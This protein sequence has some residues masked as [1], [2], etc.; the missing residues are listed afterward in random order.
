MYSNLNGL[1]VFLD[2]ESKDSYVWIALRP[3]ELVKEILTR[4]EIEAAAYKEKLI[5]DGFHVPVLTHNMRNSSSVITGLDNLYVSGNQT[6]AVNFKGQVIKKEEKTNKDTVMLSVPKAP[7]PENTV[8]GSMP[9]IIP[10][11]SEKYQYINEVIVETI[12]KYFDNPL[13]PVVVLISD[14]KRMEKILKAVAE[15]KMFM[16]KRNVMAYSPRSD[17][18]SIL[19]VENLKQFLTNPEGVLITDAEA[20]GGMQARNIIVIGEYP[21]SLRNYIMRAISQIIYIQQ[22]KRLDRW[23]DMNPKLIVDRR[24]LPD[25]QQKTKSL[26]Q[27]E[28][29]IWLWHLPYGTTEE[30]IKEHIR[31]KGHECHLVELAKLEIEDEFIGYKLTV[32]IEVLNIFFDSSN[33]YWPPGWGAIRYKKRMA[34]QKAATLPKSNMAPQ[35]LRLLDAPSEQ[36]I[37]NYAKEKGVFILEAKPKESNKIGDWI[38]HVKKE[39]YKTLVQHEFWKPSGWR[40]RSL[41]V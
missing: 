25:G 16:G 34:I 2:P 7:L 23:I 32:D 30:D 36:D 29:E 14:R 12:E 27:K 4:Y 11:E 31:R 28:P 37:V 40:V 26:F 6:K 33:P 24:Y 39:D 35:G 22:H 19:D 41:V 3:W 5:N 10:V 1:F 21:K 38:L 15:K 8:P 20:F 9:V 17:G 13:E 18:F